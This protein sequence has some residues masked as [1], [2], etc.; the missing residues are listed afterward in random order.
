M[1]NLGDVETIELV[2]NDLLAPLMYNDFLQK[3]TFLLLA[4]RLTLTKFGIERSDDRMLH[5][6]RIQ[7]NTRNYQQAIQQT[8]AELNAAR[9]QLASKNLSDVEKYEKRYE[10]AKLQATI[11]IIEVS[12]MWRD[13]EEGIR[14]FSNKVITP[15]VKA[16]SDEDD[17]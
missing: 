3:D 2:F 16:S 5:L 4:Y 14:K 17:H 10:I 1:N 13:G 9:S 7:L 8:K 6:G 15:F 11:K 12:M